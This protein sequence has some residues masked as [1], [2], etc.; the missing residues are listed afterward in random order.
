MHISFRRFLTSV[1]LVFAMLISFSPS[2][3]AADTPQISFVKVNG[4][5]VTFPDA[6]PFI[7]NGST[8]VPI[9]FIAEALKHKVEWV[10]ETRTVVIDDGYILL[11]I[12]SKT[13]TVNGTEKAVSVPAQLVKEGADTRTFVPLRFISQNLN[14]TV[15]WWSFNRSIVINEFQ[16]DGTE[17][18]LY[19]R[20]RQ[21]ENF[22]EYK[23]MH[24]FGDFGKGKVV[25]EDSYL[26]L[27]SRMK[28][29]KLTD[30]SA[31]TANVKIWR[32]RGGNEDGFYYPDGN[33]IA[34]CLMDPDLASRREVKEILRVFYPDGYETVYDYMKQ[35]ILNTIFECYKD[36][37]STAAFTGTFGLHY[38]DGREVDIISYVNGND[39]TVSINRLG[40][41]NPEKPVA[42]D[43]VA[44]NYD[45]LVAQGRSS[46]HPGRVWYREQ[47]DLD[48]W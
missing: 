20:C 36:D 7:Q 15:D 22:Y 26:I 28:S 48:E 31:I 5:K 41:K 9:R 44:E 35:A 27:N 46:D 37:G 4:A 24:D 14:C 18:N 39:T 3:A 34:V 40:Y 29:E 30:T 38:I 21:S 25:Q 16:T 8:L 11:P 12:G 23:E 43:W 2:A 1:I 33:D 32:N 10:Q 47:W 19:E 45:N 13:A 6:Q 17:V 42:L